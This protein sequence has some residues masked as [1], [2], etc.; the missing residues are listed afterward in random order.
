MNSFD[1]FK[2][3]RRRIGHLCSNVMLFLSGS[4]HLILFERD[5]LILYNA[6]PFFS[7][8]KVDV[9]KSEVQLFNEEKYRC[10]IVRIY[11]GPIQTAINISVGKFARKFPSYGCRCLRPF[12]KFSVKSFNG[13]F[14]PICPGMAHNSFLSKLLYIVSSHYNSP[15]AVIGVIFDKP[16]SLLI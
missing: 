16:V 6:W 4:R 8:S 3:F 2:I 10:S 11:I 15:D 7:L 14:F 1:Y 12:W 13:L 5:F 9:R